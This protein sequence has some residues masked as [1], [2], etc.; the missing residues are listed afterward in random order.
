MAAREIVS[1]FKSLTG[2]SW[3]TY[4]LISAN[5]ASVYLLEDLPAIAS[6]IAEAALVLRN[7][8][9]EPGCSIAIEYVSLSH[10]LSTWARNVTKH[11]L[12]RLHFV[13][14]SIYNALDK[15]RESVTYYEEANKEFQKEPEE[16][17]DIADWKSVLNLKLAEHLT[18]AKDYKGAQ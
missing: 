13:M 2:T 14:G 7:D 18:R 11:R 6:S 10:L 16:Q 9:P 17:P 12:D 3:K 1:T 15:P 4:A 5:I 8:L